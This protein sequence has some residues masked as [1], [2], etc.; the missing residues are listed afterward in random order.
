MAN[1]ELIREDDDH[2]PAPARTTPQGT[3]LHGV[4]HG[5]EERDVSFGPLMKYLTGFVVVTAVSIMI[6]FGVYRFMLFAEQQGEKTLPPAYTMKEAPPEPRLLP[7]PADTAALP[8]T[9]EWQIRRYTPL[10]GP[11]EYGQAELK[12]QREQLAALGLYDQEHGVPVIPDTALAAVPGAS[13]GGAGM[14]QWPP[15][16][17]VREMMPADASGG[18]NM[19]NRL[20]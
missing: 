6:T 7:N 3:Q 20:R 2:E 10:V 17:G 12:Q 5:H 15:E 13:A 9:P 16:P 14:D 8:N 18:S 11:G 4:E 19:E 1:H